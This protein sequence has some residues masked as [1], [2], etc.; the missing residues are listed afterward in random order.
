MTGMFSGR[1]I[2]HWN[3]NLL[4]LCFGLLFSLHAPAQ[5]VEKDEDKRLYPYGGPSPE[6]IM[7]LGNPYANKREL[8]E[9]LNRIFCD[10]D[11]CRAWLAPKS[12]GI[13]L[14]DGFLPWNTPV[15]GI[16]KTWR[17]VSK[18]PPMKTSRQPLEGV[19]I[20]IDAGHLG[21]KWAYREQRE[22]LVDGKYTVR[23]GTSTLIVSELLARYLKGM[24][25]DVLLLRDSAAPVSKMTPELLAK[26]LAKWRNTKVTSLLQRE[27]D[28]FFVRRAEINARAAKLREFKP[29]LTVCIHFDAGSGPKPVDKLHLILNGSY[30]QDELDDPELRRGMLSKLLGKV[31]PVEAELSAYV[32]ASMAQRLELPPFVYA[33]PSKKVKEV[34][35]NTYLWCR[36]LLANCLY[37]GPVIYTEPYAMLNPLTAQRMVQ[38]DYEGYLHF[39]GKRLPSIYREYARS[40]ANGIRSYFIAKRPGPDGKL[41]AR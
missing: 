3:R 23:E 19:R 21:G 37:P 5:Q 34:P 41:T 16:G 39:S 13:S 10:P 18:L 4:I 31:H 9:V 15:S 7:A 38:G 14:M 40:V 36:N 11:D 25:A 26:R 17:D 8:N 24:G 29:D 1:P 28:M 20:A 33:V 6:E 2:S 32:A 12:G 22:T 30:S 27:A 35:G